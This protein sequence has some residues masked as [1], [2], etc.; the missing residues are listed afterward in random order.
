M[1]SSKTIYA[2]ETF[3]KSP[4]SPLSKWFHSQTCVTFRAAKIV[5]KNIRAKRVRVVMREVIERVVFEKSGG[6]SAP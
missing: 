1:S 3:R 6:E 5:S 2:V 4:T